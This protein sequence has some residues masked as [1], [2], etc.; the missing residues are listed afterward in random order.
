MDLSNV[1]DLEFYAAQGYMNRFCVG[2]KEF[3]LDL[4]SARH[5]NK[6]LTLDTSNLILLINKLVCFFNVFDNTTAKN[7]LLFRCKK[8]NYSKLIT[9]LY[10]LNF[11][12]L[13]DCDRFLID[14]NMLDQL[15]EI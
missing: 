1:K 2:Y 11:L 8:E 9:I 10:F 7:I 3:R 13:K 14:K 5:I 4:D 6:M 12:D 15:K